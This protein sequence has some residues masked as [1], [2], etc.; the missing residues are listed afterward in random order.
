EVRRVLGNDSIVG[1]TV[2][3]DMEKIRWAEQAGAD[4]ISFCSIFHI[5][6]TAQCPIVSLETVKTARSLTK[7]SIFA[8]GGIALENAHLIL[9][10]G[11]DGVAVTSAIL[12][13]KDPEQAAKAFN[14]ILHKY[15]KSS[16]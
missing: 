11:V 10:A 15:G 5:C 8:A 16:S 3:V 2:N 13:A 1:Y 7:L 14:E 6:E 9:E 12:K 4:Y